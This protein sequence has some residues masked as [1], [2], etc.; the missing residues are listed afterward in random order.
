MN[1]AMAARKKLRGHHRDIPVDFGLGVL[2]LAGI[3][4]IMGG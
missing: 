4:D 1:M 2:L 3:Y